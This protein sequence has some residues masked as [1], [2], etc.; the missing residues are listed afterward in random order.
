MLLLTSEQWA[1]VVTQLQLLDASQNRIAAARSQFTQLWLGLAAEAAV[2]PENVQLIG[3]YLARPG[4]ISP[5]T[6]ACA[7]LG[8]TESQ[9]RGLY[10]DAQCAWQKSSLALFRRFL[11]LAGF[12][13]GESALPPRDYHAPSP[14]S[15]SAECDDRAVHSL[16]AFFCLASGRPLKYSQ[17][18]MSPIRRRLLAMLLRESPAAP[19]TRMNLRSRPR[20]GAGMA[21]TL[22]AGGASAFL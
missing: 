13:A 4:T 19:G 21:M 14:P 11:A 22:C 2:D 7:E 15:A 20:A 12:N 6:L 1:S 18:D 10:S 9:P 16:S 3:V 5:R 17:D 8:G